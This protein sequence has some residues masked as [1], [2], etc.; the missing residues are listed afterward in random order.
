MRREHAD[1]AVGRVGN[2][3]VAPGVDGDGGRLIELA[4]RG[5]SV[6]V[7]TGLTR[8]GH[9]DHSPARP[10]AHL[11]DALPRWL[12]RCRRRPPHPPPR[13]SGARWSHARR[14]TRRPA[15]RDAPPAGG[16]RRA[17]RCAPPRRAPGSGPC[18]PRRDRRRR[19]ERARPA[20]R[21]S[22]RRGACAPPARPPP[23][24]PRRCTGGRPPGRPGPGGRGTGGAPAP[25]HH[26]G[27]AAS[28][29]FP[30]EDAGGWTPNG[31]RNKRSRSSVW[32]GDRSAAP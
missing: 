2:E 24:R 20:S 8:A 19:R 3:E 11:L 21:A 31:A 25:G 10:A 5:R 30:L 32:A 1:A 12:R 26:A 27:P 13:P 17:S 4:R 14:R 23:P 6:T 15:W 28:G 9:G 16:D 7:E 18:R 29:A 22:L